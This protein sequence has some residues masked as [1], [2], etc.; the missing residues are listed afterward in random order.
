MSYAHTKASFRRNSRDR[1]YEGPVFASVFVE[2]KNVFGLT[3][4]AGVDNIFNA[5][6]IRNRTVFTGLRDAS[7]I[8]FVERRNRLIGPIFFYSVKGTF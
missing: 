3:V 7:P 6:S 1:I 5:R 2:N 8:D 4:R